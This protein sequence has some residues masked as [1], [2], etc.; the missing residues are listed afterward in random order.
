MQR[1]LLE[2]V[3]RTRRPD[4]LKV[5]STI[6]LHDLATRNLIRDVV[7][8]ELVDCEILDGGTVVTSRGRKLEAIIDV[9]GPAR[10]DG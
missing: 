5:V 7:G 3:V 1:T 4:L 6:E 2:D 9:L 10:E 8:E